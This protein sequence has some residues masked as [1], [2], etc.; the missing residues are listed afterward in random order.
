M[1]MAKHPIKKLVAGMMKRESPLLSDQKKMQWTIDIFQIQISHHS[2][3]HEN[4]SMREKYE[5]S[6]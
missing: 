5:N 4:L 1:K 6:R 2:S 3:S